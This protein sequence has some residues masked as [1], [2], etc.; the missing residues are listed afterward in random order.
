M[1]CLALA[2]LLVVWED[3]LYF[4]SYNSQTTQIDQDNIYVGEKYW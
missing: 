3:Q 2:T 1:F 4:M